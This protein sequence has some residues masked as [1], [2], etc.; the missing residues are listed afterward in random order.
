MKT[1]SIQPPAHTPETPVIDTK[2]H[3]AVEAAKF[4]HRGIAEIS[5]KTGLVNALMPLIRIPEGTQLGTTP[6]PVMAVL[7]IKDIIHCARIMGHGIAQDRENYPLLCFYTILMDSDKMIDVL[8]WDEVFGQNNDLYTKFI[9]TI[10]SAPNPIWDTASIG[11]IPGLSLINKFDNEAAKQYASLLYRFCRIIAYADDIRTEDEKIMLETLTT[12]LLEQTKSYPSTASEP[13]EKHAAPASN[14]D[15]DNALAKLENMIGLKDV[16]RLIRT[17]ASMAKINF[18][19]I[20]NGLPIVPLTLHSVFIGNPGTGKTM[21]ARA[22]ANI[23]HS[24]GTLSEGKLIEVGRADLVAEY[25]GQTA[26]KTNSVIDKAIGGILFIDEAYSLCN[27]PHDDYG[28]EAINT[29]LQRMENDRD[30]FVV[31]LAGYDKEMKQLIDSNPGLQSR[32]TRMVYFMDYSIRELEDIFDSIMRE[33][34]FFFGRGARQKLHNILIERLKNRDANFGNGRYIRNIFENA[35][36]EQALRLVH[37]I[38]PT[39]RQL[40]TITAQD[41]QAL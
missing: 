20:K 21:V 9:S 3:E 1:S 18:W 19:R 39:T 17:L 22:M 28:R 29:L 13:E 12:F 5:S 35:I 14:E 37:I 16:K 8:P 23:L 15:Y 2:Q 41:I 4:L 26:V 31:I 38:N 32:F 6:T 33:Y 11:T 34:Q 25:V 10:T 36:Q 40:C 7:C 27:G 24:I 30:K